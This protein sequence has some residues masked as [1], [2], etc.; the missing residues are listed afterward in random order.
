LRQ[1]KRWRSKG[2]NIRVAVNLSTAMFTRCRLFEWVMQ[3]LRTAGVPPHALELEITESVL[4]HDSQQTTGELKRLREAGVHIAVDD[5][6]TGYSSLSYLRQLPLDTLKIDR[7]FVTDLAT[8]ASDAAICG[9]IIAMA[10][11]LGL[12]VVAEGIE[13][14]LQLAFLRDRGCDLAQGFL[15]AK[16]LS[17]EQCEPF[18]N[19]PALAVSA[20][21]AAPQDLD[22]ILMTGQYA[23][24]NK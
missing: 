8:K 7:T 19:N 1:I 5:F 10:H 17:A 20:P 2:H 12:A 23:R 4:M 11:N 9:A 15:L 14:G 13:T 21:I 16:P 3:H 22:T 18:L 24:Q 6:G